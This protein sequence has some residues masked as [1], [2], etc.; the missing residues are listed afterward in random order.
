MTGLHFGA[1]PNT[2]NPGGF[3]PTKSSVSLHLDS[4]RCSQRAACLLIDSRQVESAV[5]SPWEINFSFQASSKKPR[6]TSTEARTRRPCAAP[7]AKPAAE[8]LSAALAQTARRQGRLRPGLAWPGLA[9]C[10]FGPI[11][12]SGQGNICSSANLCQ[13]DIGNV[14]RLRQRSQWLA[15]HQI[16]KLLPR[17]FAPHRISLLLMSSTVGSLDKNQ[18]RPPGAAERETVGKILSG[19]HAA[20]AQHERH[21]MRRRGLKPVVF[22]KLLGLLV[23]GMHEKGSDARVLRYGS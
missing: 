19:L 22:V 12:Q 21:R 6:I 16:V 3:I 1:P 20:Q 23:K 17:K 2:G 7:S 11:A 13:T 9:V 18:L 10:P 4:N 8:A 15:P 14:Q 5:K